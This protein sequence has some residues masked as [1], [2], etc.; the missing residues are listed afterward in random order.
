MIEYNFCLDL[1]N[2]NFGVFLQ[3]NLMI[4]YKIEIY[5]DYLFCIMSM[6][7]FDNYYAINFYTNI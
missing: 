4:K 6:R 2:N 1:K 7:I 5:I 3:D